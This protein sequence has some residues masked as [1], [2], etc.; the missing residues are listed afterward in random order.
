MC[1]IKFVVSKKKLNLE[2][3]LIQ[4]INFYQNRTKTKQIV[5]QYLLS[6]PVFRKKRKKTRVSVKI[7]SI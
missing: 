5:L 2:T 6:S 7:W 1:N 3:K 4:T